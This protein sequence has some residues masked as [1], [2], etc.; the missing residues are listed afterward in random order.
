[1]IGTRHHFI[2]LQVMRKLKNSPLRYIRH[3]AGL[4][5]LLTY[6]NRLEFPL[7]AM[8]Q[9]QQSILEELC[10]QQEVMRKELKEQHINDLRREDKW[11]V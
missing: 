2:F 4:L 10:S 11:F 9:Q 1:M 8:F 3:E 6:T 5:L 7:T